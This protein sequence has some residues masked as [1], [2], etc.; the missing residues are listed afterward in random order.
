M[1]K[2]VFIQLCWVICILSSTFLFSL[3][4]DKVFEKLKTKYLST[5]ALRISFTIDKSLVQG[6]LVVRPP[7]LF[8]L[9]LKKGKDIENIIV[10]DGKAVWNYSPPNKNVIISNILA[11]DAASIENLFTNFLDKYKAQSLASENNSALGSSLVL[12]LMPPEPANPPVRIYLD[13]DLVI[14]AIDLGSGEHFSFYLIKR[15]QI[16]P[17]IPQ[18]YFECRPPKDVEVFD[19]R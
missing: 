1:R 18:N 4:K 17:K 14:K 11:S 6:T 13:K 5:N 10:C 8:R 15:I 19:Y 3:D 7:N 2:F 16:N 9:E 12:T